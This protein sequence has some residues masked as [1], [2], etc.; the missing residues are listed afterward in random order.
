[1]GVIMR[2]VMGGIMGM[3]GAVGMFDGGCTHYAGSVNGDRA[4][5]ASRIKQCGKRRIENLPKENCSTRLRKTPTIS[6]ERTLRATD[7][8]AV[9]WFQM[10]PVPAMHFS[11]SCCGCFSFRRLN[12]RS[13]FPVEAFD[14]WH[15]EG[16]GGFQCIFR[17][18]CVS[19]ALP[20]Y[21]LRMLAS[22]KILGEACSIANRGIRLV[23]R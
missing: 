9:G 19:V 20:F 22:A 12:R 3:T 17:T 5:G 8:D 11:L 7:I 14:E 16:K 21:S 10:S 15:R 2:M 18:R 1:M 23:L 6:G 4:N 13:H